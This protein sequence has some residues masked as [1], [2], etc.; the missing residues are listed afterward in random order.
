[1]TTPT[2]TFSNL[3]QPLQLG[4]IT[5][6]NRIFMAPLTR[7][8]AGEGRVPTSLNAQYYS[9]RASA[10]LIISEATVISERGIGY[11]NTPGIYTGAQVEG[12]KKVT[13]AVHEA[14][15]RIFLQLWHCGRVGHSS[16]YAD[17]GRAVA[18]SAVK[19]ERGQA[20]TPTG[21]QPH[22]TPRA[23][24][25]Q[26]IP[27]IVEDYRLA[28]LRAKAAGFDGV[29]IHNANGY[30]LDQFLRSGT[31]HRSDAYGGAIKNRMRL[32]LEVVEA[33]T[34][35]W[36][37]DRVGIRFSPAGVFGDMFD[38]APLE[39]FSTVLKAMEPIGLA[40][41]HI[42][43]ITAQDLAHGALDGIGPRALRP[44]VST[45]LIAAGG[46]TAPK[47]LTIVNEG[48]A[49]A[50]AFGVSFIANPDLPERFL[51]NATL[52]EPNEAT[53]YTS[54]PA[55]YTNYPFLPQA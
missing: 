47:A 49:E 43:E 2:T 40:Y 14:D 4:A 3:F 38:A 46:F 35:V 36:G 32:S 53:F 1:M 24:E 22:E 45:N 41:I 13:A 6:P 52:N 31:N 10:G 28:A 37:G 34:S 50:V 17:G 18:P 15:G 44:F 54:G 48:I 19:I 27:L 29:E 26:E 5:V 55:G 11:P 7:C 20:T 16:L 23:L 21:M 42:T 39:T 9:Q 30:L 33:V 25:I 12:W 8:R 51:R